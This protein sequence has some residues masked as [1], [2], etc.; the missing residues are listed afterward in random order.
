MIDVPEVVQQ[1]LDRAASL[2]DLAG[3][4]RAKLARHWC[5]VLLLLLAAGCRYPSAPRTGVPATGTLALRVVTNVE[6]D[7][8]GYSLRVDRAAPKFVPAVFPGYEREV[9]VSELS[10][11]VHRLSVSGVAGTARRAHRA[12]SPLRCPRARPRRSRSRSC[13][14][15]LNGPR[16]CPP[17]DERLDPSACAAWY[18][19]RPTAWVTARSWC[20]RSSRRRAQLGDGRNDGRSRCAR[21]HR[22]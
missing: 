21:Q 16:R 6:F 13:A 10:A 5:S 20:A 11:G 9:I 19:P 1:G 12:R 18:S 7:P 3:P 2:Q 22:H 4:P 14:R 8:N 15:R 17:R